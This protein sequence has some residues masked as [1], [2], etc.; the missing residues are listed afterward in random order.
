MI[1]ERLRL[2]RPGAAGVHPGAVLRPFGRWTSPAR[3]AS[4]A[5]ARPSWVHYLGIPPRP[6]GWRTR[7]ASPSP[8]FLD[9]PGEQGHHHRQVS[10]LEIRDMAGKLGR[11]D[12]RWPSPATA[13]R[14]SSSWSLRTSRPTVRAV[15]PADA[16]DSPFT[17]S[18]AGYDDIAVMRRL[19]SPPSTPSAAGKQI[20]Q[21]TA[22]A[23]DK[24]GTPDEQWLPAPGWRSTARWSARSRR[25]LRRRQP[26]V[27]P[28]LAR[29]A[30]CLERP[31]APRRPEGP[32]SPLSRRRVDRSADGIPR[33]L[34]PLAVR[35]DPGQ[36]P[37][38][39]ASRPLRR[40]DRQA[41]R[42]RRGEAALAGLQIPHQAVPRRRGWSTTAKN[43][44]CR[45]P[46]TSWSSGPSPF[47]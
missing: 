33:G 1:H 34:E 10:G 38:R 32:G 28:H 22:A 4:P 19:P 37:R 36:D 41:L 17:Y 8:R 23:A 24:A 43:L 13:P 6:S 7:S 46:G 21:Q 35:E 2:V 30:R 42:R 14:T 25:S 29:V 11:D 26:G 12:G 27:E 47:R 31:D 16:D 40:Q 9:K 15:H 20:F 39:A 18:Q 3:P 44:C 5:P 45:R